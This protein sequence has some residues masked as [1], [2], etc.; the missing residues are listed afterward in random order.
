LRDLRLFLAVIEEGG[1]SA[2]GRRENLTQPA[3]SRRIKALEGE[4]GVSLLERGAHSVRPTPAG[5]L[6]AAEAVK[7]L[8]A[9][10]AALERVRASEAGAPLRVAYAPSL[11]GDLLGMALECFTQLHPRARVSLFDVSSSEMRGGLAEGRFDVIITTPSEPDDG[12]IRWIPVCPQDW[13]VAVPAGDPLASRELL[14]A[15]DL[16]GRRLL[17]FSRDDYPEYWRKVTGYFREHGINARVAG[18]FDAASSMAAAVEAGMGLALMA[19]RSQVAGRRLVLK[20]IDPAP[21][22]I[23][24]AAGVA[25]KRELPGPLEVFIEELRRAAGE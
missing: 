14:E 4:I 1:I 5:E 25:G 24:V 2:A 20:R 7:L 22:P 9:A 3:L 17:L 18:E 11:A 15:G 6:L 12:M 10:E 23:C 19:E 21:E 13:R 8:A 16:D